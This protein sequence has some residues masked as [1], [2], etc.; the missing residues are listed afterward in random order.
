MIHELKTWPKFFN[1]VVDE[2]KTF[3]VRYNDRDYQSGDLL[4]LKEFDPDTESFTGK[5]AKARITYVLH[6]GDWGI[7]SGYVVLGIKDIIYFK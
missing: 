7:E 4:V 2:G 6:G 5:A 1:R 3:E